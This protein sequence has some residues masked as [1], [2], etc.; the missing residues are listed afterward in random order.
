MYRSVYDRTGTSMRMIDFLLGDYK[1]IVEGVRSCS[2]ELEKKKLKAQLPCATIS[3]VFSPTRSAINLV[4]HSGAICIDIDKQDNLD[5]DFAWLKR[6]LCSLKETA[7]VSYSVSGNGLFLII[8]IAYPLRHKE[9]FNAIEKDFKN[10][11]IVIDAQCKDIGRLRLASYDSAPYINPHAVPYTATLKPQPQNWRN[12]KGLRSY[13]YG[14]DEKKIEYLVG[15]V[16]RMNL[17]L[18]QNYTDWIM[19]GFALSNLG[20]TGREFYHRLSRYNP[21][22]SPRECDKKYNALEGKAR[23]GVDYFFDYLAKWGIELPED[24]KKKI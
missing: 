2:D 8:P 13:A 9:H 11:G 21:K 14:D 12:V 16:E 1:V 7:Y 22:Y 19:L 24:F 17:D 15:E 18:T 4:E 23:I 20:E 6:E 10:M 3:G 5:V